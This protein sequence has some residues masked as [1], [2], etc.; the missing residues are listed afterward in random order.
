[1]L[2]R[3]NEQPKRSDS[4]SA[5]YEHALNRDEPTSISLSPTQRSIRVEDI[6]RTLAMQLV[7]HVVPALRRLHVRKGSDT[8]RNRLS[9]DVAFSVPDSR[10]EQELVRERLIA[11]E[12]GAIAFRRKLG[13]P[14]RGIESAD[15]LR[16]R[17]LT[18]DDMRD[19]W[20]S[21]LNARVHQLVSDDI[22][23]GH[24]RTT[25]DGHMVQLDDL[26]AWS[27][28]RHVRISQD[29]LPGCAPFMHASYRKLVAAPKALSPT[30]VPRLTA[31]EEAILA[32]ISG[33]GL[34]PHALPKAEK[35]KAGIKADLR[36]ELMK[37]TS[38]FVSTVTFDK[39]WNRLKKN[40]AIAYTA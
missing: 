10:E 1:M 2:H 33:R 7:A 15:H 36:D 22:K 13:L 39:A 3:N 31:Q 40:N 18:D 37:Q 32:C 9:S 27:V 35:G 30:P 21:V 5:T 6:V 25:G 23:H 24:L 20:R 29:S 8:F 4:L 28:F 14:S 38:C 12:E 19:Y 11:D 16:N 34:D 26:V 17:S